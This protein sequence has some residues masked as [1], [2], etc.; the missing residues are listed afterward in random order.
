MRLVRFF[1]RFMVAG[2]AGVRGETEMRL[3]AQEVGRGVDD[4][5][6]HA[7][8]SGESDHGVDAGGE[9]LESGHGGR[10]REEFLVTGMKLS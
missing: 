2:G 7:G 10:C 4:E 5:G 9:D 1:R 3:K 8:K 6:G